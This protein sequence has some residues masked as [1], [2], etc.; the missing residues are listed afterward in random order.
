MKKATQS[1][2]QIMTPEVQQL[3][4]DLIMRGPD[5]QHT[6]KS[7]AATSTGQPTAAVSMTKITASMSTGTQLSQKPAMVTVPDPSQII[8]IDDDEP[9][10]TTD[11]TPMAMSVLDTAMMEEDESPR[12]KQ[13][14]LMQ[15]SIN[16][17]LQGHGSE[18]DLQEKVAKLTSE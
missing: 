9:T 17:L 4:A 11:V 16:K 8:S 14:H 2:T 12:T 15:E 5:V 10:L 7:M 6:K 13:L 1:H 18:Q 3:I